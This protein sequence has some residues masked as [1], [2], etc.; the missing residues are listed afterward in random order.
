MPDAGPRHVA[1]CFYCTGCDEWLQSW[2]HH[3]SR[4]N[5]EKIKAEKLRACPRCFE[6]FLSL[7]QY[8]RHV[9]RCK[10]KGRLFIKKNK[11]L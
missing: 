3:A 7:K 11:C 8:S 9:Y 2:H 5:Q 4:C 10:V 1:L 6:N